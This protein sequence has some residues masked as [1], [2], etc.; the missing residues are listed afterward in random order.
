MM[1]VS[2]CTGHALQDVQSWVGNCVKWF[3]YAEALLMSGTLYFF[4][5][6]KR[7]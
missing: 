7:F 6:A 5:P 4:E 3:R 2:H 1:G